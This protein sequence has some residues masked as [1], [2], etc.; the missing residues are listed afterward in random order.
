[1]H[2]CNIGGKYCYTL[3]S[4]NIII[5]STSYSF[6]GVHDWTSQLSIEYKYI[7]I[8]S[9]VTPCQEMQPSHSFFKDYEITI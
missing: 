3:L 7:S 6:D 9:V 5:V 8:N 1:M 2:F 4:V